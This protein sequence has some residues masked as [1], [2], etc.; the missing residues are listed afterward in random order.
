M[1]V[2]EQQQAKDTTEKAMIAE[3]QESTVDRVIQGERYQLYAIVV[4]RVIREGRS[5]GGVV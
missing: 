3:E 1:E 5:G 4:H 2:E